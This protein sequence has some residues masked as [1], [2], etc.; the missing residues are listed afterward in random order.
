MSDL[1]I[2]N[3]DQA[4]V[5]VISDDLGKL[6][7]LSEAFA[8]YVPNH[9]FHPKVRA[10]VWDGKIRLYST[11]TKQIY[12]GLIPHIV[13]FATSRGYTVGIDPTIV[14][15]TPKFIHT[16]KE[17][18]EYFKQLQPAYKG[19]LLTAMEHQV[20]GVQYILEHARGLLLSPTG[21]GK[22][23]IIY[24]L[25]RYY[26]ENL[27][28]K[29]LLIVPTVSLVTQMYNDFIEYSSMN[30]WDVEANCHCIY[31]GKEKHSKKQ[32]IITTW[33]S[34]INQ[35]PEYFEQFS[36]VIVDEAHQAKSKSISTILERCK[37]TPVRVGLTG[38]LDGM[39]TNRLVIEGLTGPVHK[40]ITTKELMDLDLLAKLK[41]DCITLKHPE[42]EC[43]LLKGCKYQEEIEYL[44][45][46][47]KRNEFITDLTVR[48]K[49]NT[50]VLFQ[51]VEKHGEVLHEIL[52]SKIDP[53]RKLFFIHGKTDV[54]LR[55]AARSITENEE[56]AIIVAS[57]GVFSVGVNIKKLHNIVFASPS[58]SR[59]RVLQGIGRQLRKSENKE[60]AKLYDI[61]DD[62]HHKNHVNYTFKHFIERLKIYNEEHFDFDL[63]QIKI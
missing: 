33:Q 60:L 22:S 40:V 45:N 12:K 3:H 49:G 5:K 31:S 27:E 36:T 19:K 18:E 63:H 44:V 15:S 21:S 39:H 48:L 62:L 42:E 7:E 4:Y 24:A 1:E 38:T 29:V 6:L 51:Y 17:I 47:V 2:Y 46:H 61:S 26:L 58:K 43:K 53:N 37:S 35:D 41:I 55:E 28:G 20:N 30:K 10:R 13:E 16:I 50:L 9:R 14:K 56:N 8:F 32:V 11:H 23:L 52:K 59:I 57:V 54:E 25:I 34:A